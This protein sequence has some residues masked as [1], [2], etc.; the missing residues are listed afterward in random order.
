MKFITNILKKWIP[1]EILQNPIL[2]RWKIE[3]CDVK[4]NSK[5]DWTNEDHCGQYTL[6][7]SSNTQTKIVTKRHNKFH[8]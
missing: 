6:Y 4:L 5:I 2:G 3:V 1:K 7:K 8:L